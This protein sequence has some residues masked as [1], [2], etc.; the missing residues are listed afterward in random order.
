MPAIFFTASDSVASS[1]R[2]N[3]SL[4]VEDVAE[5]GG[6][7]TLKMSTLWAIL[8][9]KE[10]DDALLDEFTELYSSSSEWL[11][12]IPDTL[13]AKIAVLADAQLDSISARWAQTDEM[14]C[15]ASDA[16]DVIGAIRPIAA[17][18]I[19]RRQGFFLYLSL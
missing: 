6:I 18:A 10:W 11:N 14:A 2:L 12:R 7:D 9:S 19:E 16:T 13:T 15:E 4:P 8:D 1:V 5:L 3:H 17:R